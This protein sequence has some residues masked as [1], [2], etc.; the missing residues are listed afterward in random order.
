MHRAAVQIHPPVPPGIRTVCRLVNEQARL[1]EGVAVGLKLLLRIVS[2]AGVFYE[3]EAERSKSGTWA[4]RL[5]SENLFFADEEEDEEGEE[6]ERSA[7]DVALE[8]ALKD[9]KTVDS[10]LP[11]PPPVPSEQIEIVAENAG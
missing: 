3:Y 7:A 6:E 5:T 4:T 11:L 1:Q 8:E 10:E 2:H 9:T